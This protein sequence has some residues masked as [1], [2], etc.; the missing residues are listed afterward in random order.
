[1][2]KILFVVLLV[3]FEF[4]VC[5]DPTGNGNPDGENVPDCLGTW[6]GTNQQTAWG[7][8][9][10][11]LIIG[12]DSWELYYHGANGGSV[13]LDWSGK[14]IYDST[15]LQ[16]QL[17]IVYKTEEYNGSEWI[18]KENYYSN[19][20]NVYYLLSDNNKTMT[21]DLADPNYTE[22]HDVYT[23][24]FLEGEKADIKD[25]TDPIL[26][27]ISAMAPSYEN[28]FSTEIEGIE[29]TGIY[30]GTGTADYRNGKYNMMVT[31]ADSGIAS[32]TTDIYYDLVISFDLKYITGFNKGD[33]YIKLQGSNNVYSNQGFDI[34]L[35]GDGKIYIFLGVPETNAE[36]LTDNDIR[37]FIFP[38]MDSI[39]VTI[40]AKESKIALLLNSLPVTMVEDSVFR[41]SFEKGPI[42][43]ELNNGDGSE[44]VE[45][46]IDNLKIWDLS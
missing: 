32:N 45:I 18:D 43:F 37:D 24:H 35:T 21:I 7:Y 46:Q 8:R 19:P 33:F 39:T 42:L 40:I 4:I 28:D 11:E 13:L 20:L 3:C 14:G 15:I 17:N 10:I 23:L 31:G 1:M 38:G 5:K 30:S 22:F 44:T 34:H 29:F 6:I 41:P 26:E 2:K 9:D 16:K 27:S 36:L 25:F 12:V